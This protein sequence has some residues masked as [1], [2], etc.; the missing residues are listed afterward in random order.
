M[1]PTALLLSA[2]VLAAATPLAADSPSA[3]DIT[4][5]IRREATEH[6]QIMK[7][8]HVLTDVY[9]PRLTGSPNL[10][11]AGEWAAGQM[12]SWGMART[13][14]EPW[15]FGHP[16]WLN[17]RFSAHLTSPVKDALVGEVLA[18][19]P[20][21][22]GVVHAS[23]ATLTPPDAPSADALTAYLDG[24][25]DAVRGRIVLIGEPKAPGVTILPAA[26]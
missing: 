17:E 18:G 14:L 16:G 9:G 8:L 26:K 12:K 2:V 10:K 23:A 11:Q 25:G 4:W 3:D 24:V 6:S 13:H 5:R 7:T 1:K 22:P 21:P 19:P 20:S 15:N